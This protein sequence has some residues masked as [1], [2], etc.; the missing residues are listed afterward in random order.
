MDDKICLDACQA[1]F[2]T[3]VNKLNEVLF[4]ALIQA[5]GDES[6]ENRAQDNFK[7]GL[8]LARKV[9]DICMSSCNS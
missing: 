1:S 2:K 4:D 8:G 7:T 3:T 5:N 9:K 6:L